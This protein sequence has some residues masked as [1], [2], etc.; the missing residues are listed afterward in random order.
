MRQRYWAA[1]VIS[2]PPTA[3]QKNLREP[4]FL[5]RFSAA[6]VSY[7]DRR[8]LVVLLHT[9]SRFSLAFLKH[10]L[11][12]GTD[13]SL[14][15]ELTGH[16]QGCCRPAPCLTVGD[17]CSNGQARSVDSTSPRPRSW[18]VKTVPLR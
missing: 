17:V 8:L 4:R 15:A 12:L 9:F 11:S 10:V 5:Q 6:T 1:R 18:E 2:G 3:R 14:V 7:I 16:G 13:S